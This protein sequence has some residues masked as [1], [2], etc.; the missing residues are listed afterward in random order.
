MSLINIA[1][2]NITEKLTVNKNT[3]YWRE[4]EL[5]EH[6]DMWRDACEELGIEDVV[7]GF[8]EATNPEIS[9]EVLNHLCKK[10]N[11]DRI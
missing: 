11:I 8:L 4:G 10:F 7:M 9:S 1:M 2:K 6:F 5:E 3:S